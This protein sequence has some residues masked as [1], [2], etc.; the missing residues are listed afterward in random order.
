M[1]LAIYTDATTETDRLDLQLSLHIDPNLSASISGV[2]FYLDTFHDWARKRLGKAKTQELGTLALNF[3]NGIHESILPVQAN[4]YF[5]NSEPPSITLNVGNF[6]DLMQRSLPV[7][8]DSKEEREAT[9]FVLNAYVNE[10][11]AHETQHWVQF[12]KRGRKPVNCLRDQKYRNKLKELIA[13]E[14]DLNNPA[15]RLRVL[16]EVYLAQEDYRS[17][18]SHQQYRAQPHEVAARKAVDLFRRY[19][20]NFIEFDLIETQRLE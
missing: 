8:D 11:F 9:N 1:E 17:S 19:D 3:M 7:I 15:E 5:R 20:S 10:T 6:I 13:A 12:I 2:N 14:P 4:G 16:Q 18:A